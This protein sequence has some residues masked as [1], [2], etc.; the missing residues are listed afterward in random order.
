MATNNAFKE[1][2]GWGLLGNSAQ[3]S[4]TQSLLGN[5]Y[6]PRA[7]RM[8]LLGGTL[9]GIGM[10]LASGKPGAWVQGAVLGGQQGLDDYQQQ[11]LDAF[12]M[13]QAQDEINY[14]RSRD[15]VSDAQW[16][17]DYGL[18]LKDQAWQNTQRGWLTDEHDQKQAQQAAQ[19][20]Y[21]TGWMG[22]K[23]QQGAGLPFSPGVRSI[24]RQ[25]GVD[26]PSA[27]D[28]WRYNNAAPYAGSQDYASAFSQIAAQPPA[29]TPPQSRTIRRGDQQVTQ[30][31][32]PSTGGWSDIASGSAFKTSPDVVVNNGSEPSDARLR[33]KLSDNEANIWG[34]YKKGAD[35]S[36]GMVQ[37]LQA[38]DEL[39]KYAPQGPI[40]GRLAQTFPGFSSAGSAYQSIVSRVAPTLRVSGSGSTSDIEYEGFLNS[41]P[42]LQN[43]L[44]GNAVI[45]AVL[46]RKAQI[47]I[48]RGAIVDAYLNGEVSAV[49]ARK[50]LGALNNQS[51]LDPQVKRLIAGT[52]G[53]SPTDM[54]DD[55]IRKQLSGGAN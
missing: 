20:G 22:D 1:I 41:L 48:H 24:A 50:Q 19:Q 14:R 36:G 44:E 40:T 42:R 37:D 32:D 23:A 9:Q 17:K 12:R 34:D 25:G 52:A 8:Q 53:K 43:T 54:S 11:A 18:R 28:Q 21:V 33:G 6:D 7:A 29:L 35:V 27:A 5:Y 55:E 49:D 30:E 45:S 3:P 26:G 47:N 39:S 16:A 4:Q 10:G 15:K 46:Q 51:I 38:L 31:F 13:K 2:S